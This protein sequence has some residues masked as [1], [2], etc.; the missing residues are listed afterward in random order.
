MCFQLRERGEQGVPIVGDLLGPFF[1]KSNTSNE[2]V[3]VGT[4]FDSKDDVKGPPKNTQP[5]FE[6]PKRYIAVKRNSMEMDTTSGDTTGEQE[7][8]TSKRS[9]MS[10]D[11][12]LC[13]LMKSA[14]YIDVDQ[15]RNVF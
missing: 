3:P 11:D 2:M 1:G 10:T 14:S 15:K 13:E 8:S 9:T 6:E 4:K 5:S 7:D 12:S